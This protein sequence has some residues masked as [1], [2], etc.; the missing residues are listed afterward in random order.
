[1][2]RTIL[3]L[4][5]DRA[6]GLDRALPDKGVDLVLLEEK[7]NAIDI[8]GDGVVLVLHHRGK[9]E[10]RLAGDHAKASEIMQG[11]GEFLGC[12][13]QRLRGNAADVEAGSAMRLALLDNR[14]L[15]TELRRPDRAD[16]AAGTSADNDEIIGHEVYPF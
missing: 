13:E 8:G 16:I 3:R 2:D 9:I 10:L 1:M 6:R 11:L 4:H 15:E 14:D 12:L 5:I 7:A